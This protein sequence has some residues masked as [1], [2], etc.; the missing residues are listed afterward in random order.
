MKAMKRCV[1]D[2]KMNSETHK[3][4]YSLKGLTLANDIFEKKQNDKKNVITQFNLSKHENYMK[5][6]YN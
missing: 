5:R 1:C 2:M 4:I 6:G 3:Y